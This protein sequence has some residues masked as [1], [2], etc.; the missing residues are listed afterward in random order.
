MKERNVNTRGKKKRMQFLEKLVTDL[1]NSSNF[2]NPL[3][4]EAYP[5]N[6]EPLS[7]RRTRRPV[8]W[9]WRSRQ[10]RPS[11]Q[12]NM[13]CQVLICWV[14]GNA[15]CTGRWLF[16]PQKWLFL[17]WMWSYLTTLRHISKQSRAGRLKTIWQPIN[18]WVQEK[19]SEFSTKT[20]KWFLSWS[21]SWSY[22]DH[23]FWIPQSKYFMYPVQLV[24]LQ[25][26]SGQRPKHISQSTINET[27][28]E[29]KASLSQR[30]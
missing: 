20:A 14:K 8:K 26:W 1:E 15:S 24:P 28:R 22:S 3:P 17:A 27:Q 12:G 11:S 5:H 30:W 2:Q 9:G 4:E 6:N 10:L 23:H 21:T 7:T 13:D 25:A 29:R 16:S 19:H 18:C